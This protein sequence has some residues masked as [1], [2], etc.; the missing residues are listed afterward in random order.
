MAVAL[1]QPQEKIIPH[2]TSQ[3]ETLF[4]G[5]SLNYQENLPDSFSG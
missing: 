1:A 3:K 2:W 4:R 5:D